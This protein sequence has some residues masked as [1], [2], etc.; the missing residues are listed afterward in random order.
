VRDASDLTILRVL[1]QSTTLEGVIVGKALYEG[2][3][4][5]ECWQ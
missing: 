2:T 3:L 5:D 1:A 4:G